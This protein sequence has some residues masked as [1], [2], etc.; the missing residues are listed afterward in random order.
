MAR[1]EKS[2]IDV[3][4]ILPHVALEYFTSAGRLLPVPNPQFR[5]N[6]ATGHYQILIFVSNV[7]EPLALDIAEEPC[8]FN[9]D[10]LQTVEALILFASPE[11]YRLVLTSAPTRDEARRELDNQ[12]VQIFVEEVGQQRAGDLALQ[13]IQ[14]GPGAVSSFPDTQQP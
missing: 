1:T 5:K 7:E 2:E 3:T 6:P 13:W 10:D 8:D 12:L 4:T 11:G 14:H 9:P